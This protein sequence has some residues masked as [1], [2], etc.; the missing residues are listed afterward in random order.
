MES[1]MANLNSSHIFKQLMCGKK[2][3][4]DVHL[5]LYMKGFRLDLFF[6]FFFPQ[7]KS[8]L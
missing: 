8:K 4:N 2:K 3:L 1:E 7:I 6:V 5:H